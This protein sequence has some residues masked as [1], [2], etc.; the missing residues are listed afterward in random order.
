[1]SSLLNKADREGLEARIA[2]YVAG[3]AGVAA[4]YWKKMDYNYADPPKFEVEPGARYVKIVR[5]EQPNKS[6]TVK[7][8]SRGVH[9]FIDRRNGDILKAASWKAPA[10]HPRG[11]IYEEDYGLKSAGVSCHGVRYM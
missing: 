6:C 2:G 10:K 4:A 1:M 3:V 8:S 9:S 7:S 11:N 5:V